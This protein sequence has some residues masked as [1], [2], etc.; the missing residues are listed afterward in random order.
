MMRSR[1]AHSTDHPRQLRKSI[2]KG[3]GITVRF[4]LW[5]KLF[6][7]KQ[8]LLPM[9][10]IGAGVLIGIL[11]V[12]QGV[13]LWSAMSEP[14]EIGVVKN[15]A[16]EK[17]A[18][19]QLT[20]LEWVNGVSHFDSR[21]ETLAY[22]DY[23]ANVTVIRLEKDYLLQKYGEDLML[24]CSETMPYLVLTEDALSAMK[25]E[26][27]EHLEYSDPQSFAGAYFQLLDADGDEGYSYAVTAGTDSLENNSYEGNS[28]VAGSGGTSGSA[29]EGGGAVSSGV[30]FSGSA[31]GGSYEG[32]E[33]VRIWGVTLDRDLNRDNS[34]ARKNDQTNEK[35]T[36][37]QESDQPVVYEVLRESEISTAANQ[38][39]LDVRSGFGMEKWITELEDLGFSV[40]SGE[41]QDVNA[42]ADQW[43]DQRE[44]LIYESLLTAA[45]LFCGA[46]VIYY[47]RRV[48]ML[49]HPDFLEYFAQFDR[50]MKE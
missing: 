17:D 25:T 8:I 49:E 26:K 43:K 46:Q 48:W 45:I 37:A 9:I 5:R 7:G 24:P 14:F 29:V 47:Q 22:G 50:E 27:L 19:E 39:L 3:K 32:G 13:S 44:W 6:A 36:D 40:L 1:A 41:G 10:F 18:S 15:E 20:D 12:S 38:Y 4:W 23:R 31:Y 34:D 30:S 11:A 33:E 21:T 16:D 35:K 2:M 42:L 28:S